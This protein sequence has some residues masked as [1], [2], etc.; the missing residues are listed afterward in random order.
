LNPSNPLSARRLLAYAAPTVALQSMMVPLLMYLPPTYSQI[1]GMSLALVGVMFAL[2]RAFEAISD[3]LIGALSDRSRHPFGKRRIWMAIGVPIAILAS[4]FLLQPGADDG[5]L[6]LLLWLIVFYVGW[7]LVFIPHQSWGGELSG[8]YD[9]RTRIAGYRETGAFV[10]YLLAAL[11]P[12]LYWQVFQGVAAPTFAQIVAA[13]GWFFV[14]ALPLAVM[15]CF[16]AVPQGKAAPQTHPP[17]W[18]EL[19]AIPRRNKPFARLMTAYFIDRLAMGTYFFAQ[20]LLIGIALDMQANLLVLSLANTVAAVM[21]APLWVPI[22]RRLGKHRT[23]CLAN[24]VTILSYV[25]LF[26]AGVGEVW[27]VMASY[28]LMGLGNGGTMIT[29]PAMAADAA[30]HDE[31]QSGSAQMG[32]H[33]AFLAFVFKAGMACGPLMGGLALAWFGYQQTGQAVDAEN[34]FGIRFTAT[35]LPVLLLIPPLLLMWN[36]PIDARRHAQIRADLDLRRA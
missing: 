1:T 34:L 15:W 17:G 11:V 9:D 29:P 21:L 19:F 5:A 4:W 23:Y 13:I 12:L 14:I 20:P 25:V 8:A 32:G 36:Y 10:G 33:M 35:W 31:L 26:M 6:Y 27:V 30:D 3:P 24:A 7:T 16:S 28:I 22:T 2:G 18:R